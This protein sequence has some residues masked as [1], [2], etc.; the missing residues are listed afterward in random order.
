MQESDLF[1]D[2]FITVVIDWNV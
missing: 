1:Y 2:L